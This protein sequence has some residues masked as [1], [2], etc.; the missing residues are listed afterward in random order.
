MNVKIILLSFSKHLYDLNLGMMFDNEPK[1][2]ERRFLTIILQ[3][4]HI[5]FQ[6]DMQDIFVQAMFEFLSKIANC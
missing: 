6:G 5:N 2:N 4:I 3:I 1:E